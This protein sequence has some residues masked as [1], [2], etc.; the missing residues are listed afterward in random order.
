M[1]RQFKCLYEFMFKKDVMVKRLSESAIRIE[2]EQESLIHY[3]V[4]FY[5]SII[6]FSIREGRWF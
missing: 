2:S 4:I 5:N 6:G 1:S 3:M